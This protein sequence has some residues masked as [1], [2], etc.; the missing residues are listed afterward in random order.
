MS[1]KRTVLRLKKEFENKIVTID[2]HKIGKSTFNTATTPASEFANYQRSG[3][4]HCF[5]EVEQVDAT[6]GDIEELKEAMQAEPAKEVEEAEAEEEEV[7]E[8]QKAEPMKKSTPKPRGK[9]VT[10]NNSEK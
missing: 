2:I 1:K 4:G 8:D 9:K 7:E 3:F 6:K 10:K 5:D